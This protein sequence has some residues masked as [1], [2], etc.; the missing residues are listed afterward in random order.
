M[1]NEYKKEKAFLVYAI[2]EK[3]KVSLYTMIMDRE[4]NISEKSNWSLDTLTSKLFGSILTEVFESDTDVKKCFI[5]VP[6]VRDGDEFITSDFFKVDSQYIEKFSI[7]YD[8]EIHLMNDIDTAVI[9]YF[10]EHSQDEKNGKIAGLYLPRN[11]APGTGFIIGDRKTTENLRIPGEIKLLY[12]EIG[13]ENFYKLNEK[14]KFDIIAKLCNGIMGMISP[15]TLVI[16]S[17]YL[18]NDDI[19]RVISKM[20][21]TEGAIV[22]ADIVLKNGIKEDLE[23]GIVYVGLELI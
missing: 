3:T 5:A 19:E 9:G 22:P 10:S 18:E 8:I 17:D 23:K 21:N 14:R 20:K 11:Y 15:D 13:W 12:P 16:Y 6:G 4:G 7:K 1:T 2:E